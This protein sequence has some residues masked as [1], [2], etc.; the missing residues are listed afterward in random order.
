M[1]GN[2][3]MKSFLL[4]SFAMATLLGAAVDARAQASMGGGM[5]PALQMKLQELQNIQRR[6]DEVRMKAL[7]MP[8]VKKAA[9]AIQT[10]IEAG[11]TKDPAMA[12]K[13]ARFNALQKE[14]TAALAAN[15]RAKGT[16]LMPELEQLGTTL[17]EAQKKVLK[18]PS[19][20]KEA[21]R[22][23]DLIF[24][25][26]KRIEPK[27]EELLKRGSEISMELKTLSGGMGG[28][29]GMHSPGDGHGH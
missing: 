19:L 20:A 29:A 2:H 5:P 3:P 18:D 9:D 7:S 22:V 17:N 6:L 16:A 8:E 24:A 25:E 28:P 27:T 11:I 26:M 13:L 21:K 23:Q 10:K 4:Y 1:K 12:K 15:D 14:F